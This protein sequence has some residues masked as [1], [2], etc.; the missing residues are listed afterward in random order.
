MSVQVEKMKPYLFLLS[1]LLSFIACGNTASIENDQEIKEYHKTIEVKHENKMG[2]SIY[3][4]E[5]GKP[6]PMIFYLS[7][8]VSDRHSYEHI[9]HYLVKRGYTVIGLSTE[10][11][12]SDFMTYHFYDAITYARKICQA[13]K[14]GDER[15][16][17]LA[18]H[19]SGA[20]VLPSLAYK[21]FVK[22]QLGKE[23]RFIFGSAPWIDFQ[24]EK[25]MRLPHDT[26]F[27]TQ[28]FINDAS[29]DPRIY[30]DMYKLMDVDHKTFI[31]LK[32]G[33]NHRTPFYDEPK[34]LVEKGIYEPLANLAAFTFFHEEKEK[35][36]PHKD[37]ITQMMTIEADGSLPSNE[38]YLMILNKFR[39][40]GSPYGCKTTA[41]Y[42]AN[43]REKE[44]L[45]YKNEL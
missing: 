15:K 42:V 32:E 39:D 28:V 31:I 20:G 25:H 41:E 4:S 27:V 40:S 12:A 37:S 13:K 22:D 33:A 30:L 5:E 2:I 1:I 43:P 16:I 11:F 44:C 38:D 3:Y 18:G 19:S 21:L 9:Y 45:N 7:A 24:F 26:N 34:A 6:K 17:G 35:I 29:T 36:F 10:S 8:S 14:I 23:G